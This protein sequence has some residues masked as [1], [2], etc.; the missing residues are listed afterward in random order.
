MGMINRE[1]AIHSLHRQSL[2]RGQSIRAVIHIIHFG[3]CC[4][5]LCKID[6]AR[7]AGNEDTALIR[8]V[9]GLRGDEYMSAFCDVGVCCLFEVVRKSM[10]GL[11]DT[12][13]RKTCLVKCVSL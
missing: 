11:C 10:D 12:T 7:G 3:I 13:V 2:V 6:E 9:G 5:C 4:C 1:I 8:V